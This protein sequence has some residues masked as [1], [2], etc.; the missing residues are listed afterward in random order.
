[1]RICLPL[2]RGFSSA[3]S[4]KGIVKTRHTINERPVSIKHDR[5]LTSLY[6]DF[7]FKAKQLMRR[8]IVE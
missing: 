6:P 7:V 8:A 1:M 3:F 5:N 2:T 4:S